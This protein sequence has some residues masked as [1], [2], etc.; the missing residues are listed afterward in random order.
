MGWVILAFVGVDVGVG[1][2]V[3]YRCF[4]GARKLEGAFL[5]FRSQLPH[6]NI[7]SVYRS[8]IL[9]CRQNDVYRDA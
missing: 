7:T 3:F 5:G 6:S 1:V 4:E 8:N 2:H 9:L